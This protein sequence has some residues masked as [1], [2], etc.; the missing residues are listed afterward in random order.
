MRDG[1]RAWYF[2]VAAALILGVFV[3]VSIARSISR[4]TH[5]MYNVESTD[6]GR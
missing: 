3:A 1:F 5:R 6:S 4:M 2:L